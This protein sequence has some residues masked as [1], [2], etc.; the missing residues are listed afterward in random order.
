[1]SKNFKC[2]LSVILGVCQIGVAR[3][4][5]N[6]SY[7]ISFSGDSFMENSCSVDLDVTWCHSDSLLSCT[8]SWK[9]SYVLR[10]SKSTVSV[11]KEEVSRL[12]TLIYAC[13]RNSSSCLNARNAFKAEK[14]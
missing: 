8:D 3:A 12:F 4:E 14:S 13:D 10:Q 6:Q 1:M 5:M 11:G 7:C 9:S 2:F